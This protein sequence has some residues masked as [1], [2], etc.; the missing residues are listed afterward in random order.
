MRNSSVIQ[1]FLGHFA[2][3]R[4]NFWPC[5]V[6]KSQLCLVLPSPLLCPVSEWRTDSS[7]ASLFLFSDSAHPL[8][9][10]TSSSALHGE[11]KEKLESMVHIQLDL[12]MMGSIQSA[13]NSLPTT[14]TDFE[15]SPKHKKCFHLHWAVNDTLIH[16][17]LLTFPE[18]KWMLGFTRLQVQQWHLRLHFSLTG[19]FGKGQRVAINLGQWN[20]EYSQ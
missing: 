5:R 19:F 9:H 6:G 13:V 18:L 11:E 17:N 4:T 16:H 15:Y 10:T 7:S 2:L 12:K 1:T 20:L 14:E 8:R 3:S